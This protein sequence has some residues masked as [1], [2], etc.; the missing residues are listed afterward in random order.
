MAIKGFELGLETDRM[1]ADAE[2]KREEREAGMTDIQRQAQGVEPI[3]IKDVRDFALATA[4]LTGDVIAFKD[5]P[6]DYTRAYELLQAGYGERDL[7]KMG[8]GGAFTG[9]ITMGLIPG[10]G[11]VSRMGKNALKQ[12]A[13]DAFKRGDRKTG[14]E[15]LVNTS[16]FVKKELGDKFNKN[17]STKRQSQIKEI[18][19]KFMGKDR[20]KRIKMLD[21]PKKE[22]LYHLYSHLLVS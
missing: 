1:F 4:P 10:L 7:I 13:I 15:L 5:A 17:V 18:K 19:K 3:T 16:E 6:E 12:M 21:K 22:I 8:L 11:F 9:L 20:K 14:T 2:R